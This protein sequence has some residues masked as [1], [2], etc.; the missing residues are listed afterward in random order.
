M[1]KKDKRGLFLDTF[2]FLFHDTQI[3]NHCSNQKDPFQHIFPN[4]P[5]IRLTAHYEFYDTHKNDPFKHSFAIDMWQTIN[6]FS[7]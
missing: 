3:E 1:L 5:P 4:A 7:L 2:I 6:I